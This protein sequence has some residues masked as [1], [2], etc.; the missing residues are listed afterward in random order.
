MLFILSKIF[1][2]FTSPINWIVLLL[3]TIIFLKSKKWRRRLFSLTTILILV[4]TNNQLYIKAVNYW[5]A[6][7]KNQFDE[8]EV[9]E[10][11]I[12]AGG[13]VNYSPNWGQL[14]YN[15]RADRITEAIRL[16]RLGKIKKLYFSGESAFNIK[17]GIFYATEFLK[18]MN[19]IGVDSKDIILEKQARTTAENVKFLKEILKDKNTEMPIL[20][21]TSGWHMRRILKGFENSGL[22]LIPYPVDVPSLHPGQTW[23]DYLPSWKTSQNWQKLI[24]EIVG[25]AII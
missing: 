10:I 8:N 14:D 6:P 7:F 20:L 16:Y 23:S 5:S 1:N 9:Y 19:E 25:L 21:I 18:Y 22:Q 13:S 17:G 2:F 24:H 11:A 3:V 4:F 15:D 12:I